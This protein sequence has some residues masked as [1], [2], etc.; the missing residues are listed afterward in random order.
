M[1]MK[2]AITGFLATTMLASGAMAATGSVDGTPWDAK[3]RFMIRARAVTVIPNESS[4]TSIGGEVEAEEGFSPEVD[5]TYFFSNHF[6]AELIAATSKHD[7]GARNTSLG[8]LDLGHVW[9]LPPTLTLQYH[10]NPHGQIRPYVGAGAGYIFW[11]GE[12]SGQVNDIEYDDG[13]AYALQA[14]VDMGIDEHWAVNFDVKR[15]FHNVDAKI[16]GGAVT[17]DVDLDPWVVGAGIAYRF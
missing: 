8:N 4:S 15:L 16:N 7:M 1:N 14:G 9:A 11:Y 3:E 2:T 17:A 5:F 6:A 10:F 12:E 13:I